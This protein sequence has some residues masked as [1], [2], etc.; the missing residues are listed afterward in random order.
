MQLSPRHAAFVGG[1]GIVIVLI[2]GLLISRVGFGLPFGFDQEWHDFLT[3]H[4]STAALAVALFLN[5]A[6][7][8]LV[9]TIVTV[10]IAAVLAVRRRFAAATAVALTMVASSVFSTLFKA[11]TARPR[12]SDA[13]VATGFTSFPSGHATS[14]AAITIALLIAFPHVWSRVLAAVWI[15]M[16]AIS[17]NY[18]LVHWLSDVVAGAVLGASVAFLVA[19]IVRVVGARILKEPSPEKVP[20]SG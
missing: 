4:Q 8:T 12:P 5:I 20:I 13:T 10:V 18:L 19:A 7:G 17:R 3:D 2:A 14:A 11:I 15:P 1:L 6:G 16:M 9:T